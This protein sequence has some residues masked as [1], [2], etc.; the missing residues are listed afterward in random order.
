[1]SDWTEGYVSDIPYSLGFYRENTPTHL[2]FAAL[3]VGA[4]PGLLTHPER[5]LE[6][7]FGMGLGFVLNAAANPA[8]H[9]EGVDFNPE[10]VAHA[11][12]LAEDAGLA[13]VSIREASFQHLAA[14]AH[15]TQHDLDLILVHG[16]LSWVNEEAQAA[17]V[18]I[19]RKRLKPGGALYASYNVMPGWAS[20]LPLQRLLRE[21]AARQQGRSDERMAAG[22]AFLKEL[23]SEEARFLTSNATLGNR[24]ES[25][26][27]LDRNYLAHEYLNANW[28]IFYFADM[29]AMMGRAKLS[30][31]GSVALAENIDAVSVPEKMRARVAATGDRIWKETLR[32]YGSN[33]QFRRDLFQRGRQ[34]LT[35]QETRALLVRSRFVLVVPRQALTLAVKGPLGEIA[36]RDDLAHPVADLL[37]DR[38]AGFDEIAALSAFRELGVGVA[39]QTLALLVHSGQV[40][41]LPLSDTD[42][43]EPARRLNHTLVER[44]RGGRIYN[45][46]AAPV[47]GSAIGVG[48]QDLLVLAAVQE[49]HAGTVEEAVSFATKFMEQ[50]QIRPN[51]DGQPLMDSTESGTYLRESIAAILRDK[52][53]IWRKLGIV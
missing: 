1:M 31:T 33:A 34:N 14:E 39:L 13:N 45:F 43:H 53:P 37:A 21:H 6:L 12:G 17:I 19:A 5:V 36:V 30:F 28:T 4:Q 25:F 7:G 48:A 15:D 18:E 20:T 11:R 49:G 46:V 29:A 2:A 16:I 41:P 40:M 51:R 50:S 27:K 32:D 44:L 9:F 22:T 35:V 24:I 42:D 38:I 26:A 52:L 10:H 3:S 23:Q 47:I 8:A